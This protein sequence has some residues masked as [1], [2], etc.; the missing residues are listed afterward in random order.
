M[1]VMMTG[2]VGSVVLI[3]AL[4]GLP[5]VVRSEE[6][7]PDPLVSRSA[8]RQA[9]IA[10]FKTEFLTPDRSYAPRARGEAEARLVALAARESAMTDVQFELALTRIVALADNGH[11][12]AFPGPRSRRYNRV[13]IR[14][15]PFGD[16]FYVLRAT[17]P[18]ADLLGTQLTAIDAHPIASV[19]RIART[20]TGGIPAWRDRNAGYFLESPEQMNALGVIED[21]DEATYRFTDAGGKVIERRLIAEAVGS[22]RPRANADRWLYPDPLPEEGG[23]WRALVAPDHAPAAFQEA[24]APFRSREA[25]EIAALVIELRQNNDA[26]SR[27]IAA[28]LADMKRSLREHKPRNVVVD[29]RMNGGGDLNT[30]RDFMQ[31]LPELV[32]GRIFVLTS[33]WTF[34]AGIS[35]V[36]YLKQAA[37]ERVTIVGEPV[38]DR[39]NFFAEGTM[40]TLANSGMVLL[41]A[42][43]RHDYQTGCRGMNDCHGSVVRYPIAVPSLAPEIAAP[44]TIEAF[45]AGRDPGMEAIATALS[46]ADGG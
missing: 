13:G 28:F 40:V 14:L 6:T 37:P 43:E 10:Q 42:T 2:S 23:A 32:P 19:R 7:A 22:D 26:G 27:P 18:N 35:S 45:R 21:D 31:H 8:A 15:V 1:E 33:P 30:T 5:A 44:W 39:L 24:D 20:L 12:V 29:M 46:G 38:G 4:A 11:T 25:R 9:D 16:G 41:N 36:G 17:A 34:S 3:A